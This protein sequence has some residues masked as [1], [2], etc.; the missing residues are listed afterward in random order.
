MLWK[1]LESL[2]FSMIIKLI[3]GNVWLTHSPEL[4]IIKIGKVGF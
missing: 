3:R 4:G 2:G 1:V